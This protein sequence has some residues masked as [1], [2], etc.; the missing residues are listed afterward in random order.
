MLRIW[1]R[2]IATSVWR[3]AITVAAVTS[4]TGVVINI[5]TDF[6]HNIIAWIAVALLTLASAAISAV[7]GRSS[8]DPVQAVESNVRRLAC[9]TEQ[10][11][12]DEERLRLAID[13]WPMPVFFANAPTQM[14]DHWAAIN[15]DRH[16]Q[17]PIDL[18]GETDLVLKVFE[19]IPSRRLVI[20]GRE[21]SGK[22]VIAIRFI[23]DFLKQARISTEAPSMVPI[24]FQTHSWHPT[25]QRLLEWLE[26]QLTERYEFTGKKIGGITVARLLLSASRVL[27]VFDG[28]DELSPEAR[29]QAIKRLNTEL[30]TNQPLILT[31]RPH[32]YVSACR[33]RGS[34][35][36]KAAGAIELQPLR[37]Y[38]VAAY[39]TSSSSHRGSALWATFFSAP[40]SPS[41]KRARTALTSPLMIWLARISYNDGATDP[42]ELADARRFPNRRAIETY[43]LG[44]AVSASFDQNN[45][46]SPSKHWSTTKATVW[47]ADIALDMKVLGIRSITW[48]DLQRCSPRQLIPLIHG[49]GIFLVTDI[50]WTVLYGPV[51]GFIRGGLVQVIFFGFMRFLL[52]KAIPS[53]HLD[54]R[55]STMFKRHPRRTAAVIWCVGMLP[56]FIALT[57]S[58]ELGI[59]IWA[60]MGMNIIPAVVLI[61]PRFLFQ[62]SG[63]LKLLRR[64]RW[65]ALGHSLFALFAGF[66][67]SSVIVGTITGGIFGASFA[68]TTFC[69][70]EWGNYTISRIWFAWRGKLPWRL[71]KFLE[72]SHSIGVVRHSG[73]S[74]QFR[75]AQ[76]GE[77][78]ATS[79]NTG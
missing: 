68:I 9:A 46:R 12:R 23:L 59:F 13:P 52:A 43:L 67:A 78:L 54:K 50:I 57:V 65:Y 29:I 62:P 73:N 41:L 56:V 1:Q 24:L 79:V 71:A 33:S 53:S 49:I 64:A 28:L 18:S 31:S 10:E 69:L 72:Y 25:E 16:D 63:P 75:H 3:T 58:L 36:L 37:I 32:E 74:Y 14:M 47:L 48:W 22:T 61:R 4:A 77:Q 51:I 38:D 19:K 39:L 26:D 27:P 60:A 15:Q 8:D 5:A 66:L 42:L 17:R 2:Y 45:E 30:S 40:S 7:I 34:N 44:Q 70:T 20:L 11:L 6:K 76:L 21:G 55:I 35:V